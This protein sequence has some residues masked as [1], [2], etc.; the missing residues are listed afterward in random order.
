MMQ[1]TKSH[2]IEKILL[3]MMTAGVTGT[4]C[5]DEMPTDPIDEW[6]VDQSVVDEWD[7]HTSPE[8]SPFDFPVEDLLIRPAQPDEL[9]QGQVQDLAQPNAQNTSC[10]FIQ[11]GSINLYEGSS[12]KTYVY[13]TDGNDSSIKICVGT[14]SSKSISLAV[15]LYREKWGPDENL[16]Y[17]FVYPT[18]GALRA[19]T[20]SNISTNKDY[21]FTIQELWGDGHSNIGYG[22]SS[23]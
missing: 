12:V 21:Y 19:A 3:L 22:I 13:K 23:W 7:G 6:S 14:N 20:W 1:M 9:T 17:K 11:V 4:G 16:G 5:S 2:K 8:D 18:L 15:T 10:N